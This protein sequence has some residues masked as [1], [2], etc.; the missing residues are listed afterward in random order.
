MSFPDPAT[1]PAAVGLIGLGTMGAEMAAHVIDACAVDGAPVWVHSRRRVSAQRAEEAGARWAATAA[2][3]ARHCSV[4]LTALPDLPQLEEVLDGPE[5]LV[6]GAGDAV[7]M[8]DPAEVSKARREIVLVVCSTSSPAGVRDLQEHLD[9]RSGGLVRVVDAP[10][11]GGREGARAASLS[12]FAGGR[13]SDVARASKVLS[14][15][16]GMVH[17][18][19][20]GAGQVAKACNQLIVAATTAA[21]AESAVLAERSGLNLQALMD[22]LG[23]GYAGSRLLEVKAPKLI[24]HDHSPDSPA[25][26]MIKDLQ[27]VLDECVATDTRA[28]HAQYLQDLYQ[29]VVDAGLGDADSTVIQRYLGDSSA[30]NRPAGSG[31]PE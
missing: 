21:L 7:R 14:A 23:G 9:A 10:I 11:S 15:C 13:D 19:P 4:I 31:S 26:L 17:L 3:V 12:I 22:V 5:G 16:G 30:S 2:E 18:G 27:F 8:G 24:A 25:G 29:Q 20:L 6:A 1:A 28:G